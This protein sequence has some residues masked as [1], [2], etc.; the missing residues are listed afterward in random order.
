MHIFLDS[1][2][3]FKLKGFKNV[4]NLFNERILIIL[5]TTP[6]KLFH[7]KNLKAIGIIY[8]PNFEK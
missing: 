4:V 6:K 3:I 1:V 2:Y 5:Q 8:K 7:T